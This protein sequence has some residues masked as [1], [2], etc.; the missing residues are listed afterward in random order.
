ML[1]INKNQLIS[2]DNRNRGGVNKNGL[3]RTI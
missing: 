1:E 3:T 2:F